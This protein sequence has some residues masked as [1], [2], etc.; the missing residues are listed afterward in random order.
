MT[1]YFDELS[2]VKSYFCEYLVLDWIR[3]FTGDVEFFGE[4]LCEILKMLKVYTISR[5][6]CGMRKTPGIA[7]CL[8]FRYKFSRQNL[9]RRT[10]ST[11]YESI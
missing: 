10:R 8:S 1:R 6:F 2:L 11:A 5:V 7:R 4:L 3:S 9:I